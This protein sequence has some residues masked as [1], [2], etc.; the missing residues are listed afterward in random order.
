MHLHLPVPDRNHAGIISLRK[1]GLLHGRNAI[2]A[3]N[4]TTIKVFIETIITLVFFC[5]LASVMCGA[6]WRLISF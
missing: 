3:R 1:G 6:A 5:E 4:H 2:S